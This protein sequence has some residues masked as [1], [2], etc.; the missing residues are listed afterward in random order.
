VF[1]SDSPSHPTGPGAIVWPAGGRC[2]GGAGA[3]IDSV[4]P[5]RSPAP[6][7]PPRASG[8]AVLAPAGSLAAA[9]GPGG[10]VVIAGADPRGPGRTLVVEGRAG[11]PFSAVSRGDA[12]TPAAA[13]ATAYL[14]DLALLGPQAGAL[15]LQVQRWFGGRVSPRGQVV[16][17]HGTGTLTVAM[18]FRSDA[19]AVWT[20]GD[21]V[22]ARAMPASGRFVAAQRLGPAGA[23]TRIAALLSDDN[24][25]IV[26]WSTVR[27][28]STDVYLDQ[29]ATGPRFSTP[30]RIEHAPDAHGLGPPEG[31][32]QLIRLSSE[33]VMCAWTG[34]SAGRWAVRTAPIDQRGLQSVATLAAPGGELVLDALA[35]GPRGEAVALLSEPET[36]A[37]GSLVAGAAALLAARGIDAAPGRTL[38]AA[39]EAVA[40]A[41]PVSGA[42]VG[43][44]PGTDRALVAWRGG[45]GAIEYSQHAAG[46]AG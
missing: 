25:A 4:S 16:A 18:D 37:T 13:L 6:P 46:P 23:D 42:T 33:S 41:G 2:P 39:P 38:F 34:V 19:I 44:E 11:A 20:A 12:R 29:S 45:A 7:Q 40:P 1:P 5:G 8:G 26:M 3:R 43:I 31:S 10:R 15:T 36:D 30:R 27:D 22:W 17:S 28:G 32:P 14:G 21:A 35:P 24:R 9:G